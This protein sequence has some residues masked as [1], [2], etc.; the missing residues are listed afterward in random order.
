LGIRTE[1]ALRRG[2]NGETAVSVFRG[3]YRNI[4]YEPTNEV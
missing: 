2:K 3:A 4:P 1:V